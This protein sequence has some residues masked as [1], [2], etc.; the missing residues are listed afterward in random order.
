MRRTRRGARHARRAPRTHRRWFVDFVVCALVAGTILAITVRGGGPKSADASHLP[1]TTI[2]AT[3]TTAP[4]LS[5]LSADALGPSIS[6]NANLTAAVFD[7][8]TSHFFVLHP[9]LREAT[10]SIVKMDIM[11]TFFA[12]ER[13][14]QTFAPSLTSELQPMVEISSNDAATTLWNTVGG[15]PAIAR[16]D[17]GIGMRE[18]T[19][20]ACLVCNGFPWPGWGLTTTSARDQVTLLRN[21]LIEPGTVTPKQR[22]LAE[23]LLSNVIPSERWGISSGVP[24]NVTVELKNG[25]VPL[26]DGR[27]QINSIGHIEG[28]GR[29][30]LIAILSRENSSEASGIDLVDN[31]GSAVFKALAPRST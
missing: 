30:Y 2:P 23:Q 3:T 12:E 9:G 18:T 27:W 26:Q 8:T 20:S 10:A 16:F 6:Q 11:A 19:P 25:W 5:P 15:A 31:V 13:A 1:S 7:L 4:V 14:G 21:L 24:S 22:N 29:N 17:D 28:D